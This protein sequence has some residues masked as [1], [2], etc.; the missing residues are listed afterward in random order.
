MC[1]IIGQFHTGERKEPVNLKIL[2]IFEDQKKRGMEGFG[3]VKIYDNLTYKVDRA[4]EPYKFMFDIHQ[5]PVRMM[6]CH[7]RIPTATDNKIKQTH[8]I[9]V[10][11]GSLR[12]KY[13]VVHNGMIQND[14][15]VKEIHE[16]LGFVYNTIDKSDA[17]F[18]PRFNDS[19][20]VAIDIAR[21]IEGQIEKVE[22]QGS[23]AFIAL[24]ITR[25]TKKT[26]E[27]IKKIF[28]GRNKNPL[29]MAK[30]R[31]KLVLSSEGPGTEITPNTLYECN[32]DKEMK[33]S[34]RAMLIPEYA[35]CQPTL[36]NSCIH[37]TGVTA[38]EASKEETTFTD[39][40]EKTWNK[41]TVPENYVDDYDEGYS[42][43]NGMT[44]MIETSESE[45]NQLIDEYSWELMAEETI[46]EI[47]T[48][49]IKEYCK[50]IEKI[51]IRML[52]DAKDYYKELDA[53]TEKEADE[54]NKI[55]EPAGVE[56]GFN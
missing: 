20:C 3:L 24:Q 56:I 7:H 6:L 1:G 34:K 26:P 32:L 49:D 2:E 16:K 11:N 10:D 51:F 14:D 28:F 42:I 13:L 15:N 21:F 47:T 19:E 4:T 46:G 25:A 44:D 23:V 31:G 27:K 50:E 33:L 5:D 52:S 45:I 36:I 48:E 22:I 9:M 30:T 40:I 18:M 29:N 12:Y 54:L 39:K 35:Y 37:K 38:V 43:Q 55:K 53:M 8:P 17:K 41:N